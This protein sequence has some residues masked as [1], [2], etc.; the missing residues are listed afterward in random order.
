[1]NFYKDYKPRTT[2]VPNSSTERNSPFVT[3]KKNEI[4]RLNNAYQ[5]D[6]LLSG[7]KLVLNDQ[8]VISFIK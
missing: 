1:M 8:K 4:F 6:E 3:T 7:R 5:A 2:S